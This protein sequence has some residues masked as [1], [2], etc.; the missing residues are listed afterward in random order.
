MVIERVL[1]LSTARNAAQEAFLR[2]QLLKADHG[3]LYD[4]VADLTLPNDA[5]ALCNGVNVG[6]F[7]DAFH[8]GEPWQ[9]EAR[10]YGCLLYRALFGADATLATEWAR[11]CELAKTEQTGLRLEIRIDQGEAA[12]PSAHWG[13][14]P[15]ALIPFELLHDGKRFIFRRHNWR[16]LRT[17]RNQSTRVPRERADASLPRVLLGCANVCDFNGQLLLPADDF[18]A[19]TKAFAQ[20]QASGRA[21]CLPVLTHA[22]QQQLR[23]SLRSDKPDMLIWVGHGT[24]RGS[25]LILHNAAHP[26][27]PQDSGEA[28]SAN[29]FATLARLG[30]LDLAFLWSCHGAGTQQALDMG[31]AEALLDPDQG[32]L[33]AVLAPNA[34]CS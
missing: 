6:Q 25:E 30:E 17:V 29:D 34:S 14:W 5:D 24:S 22:T 28:V 9:D 19:H 7:L 4:A 8:A 10:A 15:L 18:N 26:N 23:D 32:N 11:A 33:M 3:E 1:T 13:R 20:L 21:Q 16:S 2:V 12:N 27:Y 31:V